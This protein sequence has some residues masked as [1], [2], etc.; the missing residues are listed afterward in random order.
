MSFIQCKFK[1]YSQINAF[2]NKLADSDGSLVKDLWPP[3][4]AQTID[5]RSMQELEQWQIVPFTFA[6]ICEWAYVVKRYVTMDYTQLY[7]VLY[8]CPDGDPSVIYPVVLHLQGFLGRFKLSPLGT[9][10]GY[11]KFTIFY[12]SL[13]QI[14]ASTPE[15]AAGA[16][17]YITLTSGSQN[18][19]WHSTNNSIRLIFQ[20]VHSSLE[21]ANPFIEPAANNS[22]N[23]YIQRR[24]FN[25]V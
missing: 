5:N 1:S 6:E 24:I 21:G 22:R 4:L 16:I 19:I 10:N 15:T 3:P 12:H 14:A 25:K 17:Q 20:L 11:V 23:V 7:N 9:W 8:K 13:Q 18:D 2:A